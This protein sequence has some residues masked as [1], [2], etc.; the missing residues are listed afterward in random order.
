MDN[1]SVEQCRLA[2]RWVLVIN[3]KSPTPIQANTTV[4]VTSKSEKEKVEGARKMWGALKSTTPSVV[5]STLAKLTTVK[6]E[7]LLVK[8]KYKRGY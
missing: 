1:S 8:R 6:Q 2:L 3:Y 5:S 4:V 7:E